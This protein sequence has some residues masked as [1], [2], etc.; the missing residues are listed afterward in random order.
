MPSWTSCRVL[1]TTTSPTW[2]SS[3]PRSVLPRRR[4]SPSRGAT[5]YHVPITYGI[6]PF[7]SPATDT[8]CQHTMGTA[9]VF[10]IEDART[11][12]RFVDIGWVDGTIAKARFYA[13]AP[14]YAPNGEMV[15]RLCVIDP[16]ERT[17]TPLQRR[18]L[19]T[20][21]ASITQVIELR[22]LR[23]TRAPAG[24]AGVRPDRGDRRLPARGGAQ[25]RPAGPAQLDHGVRGDARGRARRPVQPC[26]RGPAD[27]HHARGG[28]HGRGCSTSR[29]ST[30]PPVRS[31]RSP[32]STWPSSPSSWC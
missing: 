22:L 17:L 11:D 8:F 26:G 6:E 24:L 25:P 21:A 4:A 27:P 16:S 18:S 12:Q 29:W 23:D 5:Q 9:D 7:V 3:S 28:A 32:R 13:S 1:T 2:W 15:G 20:L 19:E 31:P 30:A 10:V 14:L